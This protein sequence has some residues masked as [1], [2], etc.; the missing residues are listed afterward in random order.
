MLLCVFSTIRMSVSLCLCWRPLQC[1]CVSSVYLWVITRLSRLLPPGSAEKV[2]HP[3]AQQRAGTEGGGP[4]GR[5]SPG[6]GEGQKKKPE[7]GLERKKRSH[8]LILFS[9]SPLLPSNSPVATSPQSPFLSLA[10]VAMVTVAA[11]VWW[12]WLPNQTLQAHGQPQQLSASALV[13]NS[14]S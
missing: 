10:L 8:W 5:T 14:H 13:P 7:R 6:K 2:R 11:R 9:L 4:A 3:P 1:N 12:A